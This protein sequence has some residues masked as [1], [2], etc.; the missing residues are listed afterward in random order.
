MKDRLKEREL[1]W[2][3]KNNQVDEELLRETQ[4]GSAPKSYIKQK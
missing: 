3:R 1:G 2:E 4:K